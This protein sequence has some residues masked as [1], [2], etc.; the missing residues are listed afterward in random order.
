MSWS[1]EALDDLECMV[2]GLIEHV[3]MLH[4]LSSSFSWKKLQTTFHTSDQGSEHVI[5]KFCTDRNLLKK[6]QIKLLY[7]GQAFLR[8]L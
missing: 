8:F 3:Q 4:D 5:N 2:A 7:I 6:P 1:A